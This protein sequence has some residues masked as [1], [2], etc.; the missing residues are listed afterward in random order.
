MSEK[1]LRRRAHAAGMVLAKTR[2][3]IDGTSFWLL[4]RGRRVI[5]VTSNDA[6]IARLL[7][8]AA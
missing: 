7:V 4:I 5:A 6:H 1:T 8:R 3:E 2:T